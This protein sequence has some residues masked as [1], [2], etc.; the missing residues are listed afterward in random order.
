MPYAR[1]RALEEKEILMEAHP[2]A[3]LSDFSALIFHGLTESMPRGVTAVL[4]ADGKNGLLPA[5][6]IPED[7]ERIEMVGGRRVASVLGRE[8]SWRRVEPIRYFGFEVLPGA[9]VSGPGYHA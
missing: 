4:S 7:W 9:G 1:G 2:Y 6:T 5:D 3:A 8:V